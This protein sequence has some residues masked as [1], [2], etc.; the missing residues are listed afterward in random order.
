MLWW[1]V[2]TGFL[3]SLWVVFVHSKLCDPRSSTHQNCQATAMWR[4][5]QET[6]VRAKPRTRTT[7]RRLGFSPAAISSEPRNVVTGSLLTSE[8]VV[9]C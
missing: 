2:G 6:E 4:I 9:R 3:Q 8:K 5:L 7:R 1:A